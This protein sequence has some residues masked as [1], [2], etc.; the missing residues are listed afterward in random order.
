MSEGVAVPKELDCECEALHHLMQCPSS[1]EYFTAEIV[2]GRSVL[3][4][5]GLAD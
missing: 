2:L 4:C 5:N 3:H 1:S